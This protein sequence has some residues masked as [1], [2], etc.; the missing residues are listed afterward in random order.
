MG[1]VIQLFIRMDG[2]RVGTDYIISEAMVICTFIFMVSYNKHFSDGFCALGSV[3][4]TGNTIAGEAK[5]VYRV[6]L[7]A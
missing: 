3:P 1:Q 7:M 6:K 5:N 4:H 2:G